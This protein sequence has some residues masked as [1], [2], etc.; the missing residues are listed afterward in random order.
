MDADTVRYA[1]STLAQTSGTLVAFL[2]AIGLYQLQALENRRREAESNLRRLIAT[3]TF[4]HSNVER[5]TDLEVYTHVERILRSTPET[6]LLEERKAISQV[7]LEQS[8]VQEVR[9]R[10]T[11]TLIILYVFVIIQLVA[12]GASLIGFTHIHQLVGRAWA[13]I[14]FTF[15]SALVVFTTAGMI[16]ELLGPLADQ[17]YKHVLRHLWGFLKYPYRIVVRRLRKSGGEGSE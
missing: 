11:E 13:E 8:V 6:L 10:R 16:G 7:A 9:R 3:H 4:G 1:L 12:I 15:L 2:G 14:A 5:I 17:F